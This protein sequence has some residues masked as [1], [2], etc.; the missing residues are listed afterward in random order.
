MSFQV[1]HKE[2]GIYQGDFMGL[3][4]WY[5]ESEMPEQGF[6]EFPTEAEAE[7][8]VQFM[9]TEASIPLDDGC[10]TVEPFDRGES[11]RLIRLGHAGMKANE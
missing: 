7:Q 2:F 11:E 1:R 4:F 5:P 8:F 9:L 3:G 10:L 6:C